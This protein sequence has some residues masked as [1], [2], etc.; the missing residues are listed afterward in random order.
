MAMGAG[1]YTF[2]VL[3]A[4]TTKHVL[5]LPSRRTHAYPRPMDEQEHKKQ[6]GERLRKARDSAGLF[7]HQAAA[8]IAKVTGDDCPP[9]RVA[10]WEQGTRLINPIA[11]QILSKLYGVSPSWIYGF[12][13]ALRT[14]E[15]SA[16]VAIYRDTD[17][18]GKRAIRGVAEAQPTYVVLSP[19]KLRTG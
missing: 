12:D 9:T 2:R 8:H 10:N 19:E 17:E 3:N 18:R 16:L 13:D 14:P 1:S 15:E 5:R 4:S 6:T 11:V 7:Q